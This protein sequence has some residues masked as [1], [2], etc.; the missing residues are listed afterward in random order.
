MHIGCLVLAAILTIVLHS[1]GL[2]ASRIRILID[3]DNLTVVLSSKHRLMLGLEIDSF[4]EL[5]LTFVDWII[6]HAER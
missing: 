3:L 4:M 1:D 5:F 6:A 2:S